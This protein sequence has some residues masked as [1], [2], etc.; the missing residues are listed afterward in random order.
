MAAPR[1]GG[2]YRQDQPD[3]TTFPRTISSAQ[4][5][6]SAPWTIEAVLSERVLRAEQGL[7]TIGGTA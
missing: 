7:R 2:D 6:Y 3:K 5:G 4:L 1:H